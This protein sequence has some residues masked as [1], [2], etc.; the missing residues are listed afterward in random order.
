MKTERMQEKGRNE[1]QTY[2]DSVQDVITEV[3]EWFAGR[4]KTQAL[5]PSIDLD[6]VSLTWGE[7]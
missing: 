5:I 7:G 6:L 2:E 3:F 1:R 4:K